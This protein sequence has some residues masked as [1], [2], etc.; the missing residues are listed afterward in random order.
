MNG[1]SAKF[2]KMADFVWGPPP[3]SPLL[4]GSF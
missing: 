1:I 3:S 4:Y 2:Q